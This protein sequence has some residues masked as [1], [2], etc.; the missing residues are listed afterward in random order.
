M[1]EW[2][3]TGTENLGFRSASSG[4]IKFRPILRPVPLSQFMKNYYIINL[5]AEL[6]ES[7]SDKKSC[8]LHSF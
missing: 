5:N 4:G 6:R 2:C 3:E 1:S 7:K 8:L